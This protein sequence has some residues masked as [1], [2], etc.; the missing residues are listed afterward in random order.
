VGGRKKFKAVDEFDDQDDF[1]VLMNPKWGRA[2][3]VSG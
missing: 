2:N 3:F 1:V